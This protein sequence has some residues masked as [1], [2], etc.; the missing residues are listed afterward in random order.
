M[1]KDAPMVLSS[2]MIGSVFTLDNEYH[3][4]TILPLW[5]GVNLNEFGISRN[6]RQQISIIAEEAIQ[7]LP[8]NDL[9]VRV[10]KKDA[11]G[12]RNNVPVCVLE[13]LDQSYFEELIKLRQQTI[14]KID[15]IVAEHGLCVSARSLIFSSHIN[16]TWVPHVATNK[17]R[18]GSTLIIGQ[19]KYFDRDTVFL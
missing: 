18:V 10:K 4:L 8:P 17:I 19:V 12:R 11:F 3:H 7:K 14:A 15:Q 6:F 9:A 5:R 1:R 16:D 2:A 13:F